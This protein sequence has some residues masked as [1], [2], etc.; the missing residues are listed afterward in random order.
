MASKLHVKKGDTVEVISGKDK[1]V[2]GKVLKSYPDEGKVIVEGVNII[3][4]HTKG[5]QKDPKGGIVEKEAPINVSNVLLY[6]ST[7]KKGVRYGKKIDGDKK[8][9]VCKKCG[10]EL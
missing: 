8:V 9:R 2:K 10:K 1:K 5:T 6:C 4:K 3:K 7:C